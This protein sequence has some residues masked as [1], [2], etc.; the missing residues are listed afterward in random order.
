MTAQ[1]AKGT[2]FDDVFKKF[3]VTLGNQ[4]EFIQDI[5]YDTRQYVTAST[6]SLT[7]FDGTG[8]GDFSLTNMPGQTLPD[9]Q[10]FLILA[11]T[12][13]P[14]FTPRNVLQGSA[15]TAQT[16]TISDMALL[17]QRSWFHLKLYSKD[18]AIVPLDLIPAGASVWGAMSVGNTLCTTAAASGN[19]PVYTD[20]A[21]NGSGSARDMYVFEEPLFIPPSV[22][23]FAKLN[24]P[25]AVTLANGTSYIR[26]V[27][28]GLTVRPVV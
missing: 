4:L 22:Q 15:G 6:T 23:I 5:L 26:F 12:I 10:G 8:A 28:H 20:W 25:S 9:R 7:L 19:V 18:Y 13:K 1:Q 14:F 3:E 2:V 24:W 21:T 11:L 27:M 16:G 17:L